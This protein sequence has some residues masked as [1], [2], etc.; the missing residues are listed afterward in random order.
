MHSAKTCVFPANVSG[1]TLQGTQGSRVKVDS[2]PVATVLGVY[3]RV[4]GEHVLDD[5]RQRKYGQEIGREDTHESWHVA[6]GVRS[7]AC[8]YVRNGS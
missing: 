5:S 6:V 1:E 3:F 4:C 7:G 2:E 8:P